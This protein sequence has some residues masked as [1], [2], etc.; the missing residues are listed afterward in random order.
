[1]GEIAEMMLEGFLDEETGELIDG[2]APGYP[3]AM[4]R[5]PRGYKEEPIARRSGNAQP[6]TVRDTPCPTCGKKMKGELGLQ[7]HRQ[8]MAH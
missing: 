7:H 2:D 8:A 3:R 6:K 4:S 5:G 1:M